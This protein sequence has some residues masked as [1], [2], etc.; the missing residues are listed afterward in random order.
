MRLVSVANVKEPL[1]TR[2]CLER[3]AK[4]SHHTLARLVWHCRVVI[5]GPLSRRN[6]RW[7]DPGIC[8][9]SNSPTAPTPTELANGISIATG[10]SVAATPLG[11]LGIVL[12]IAGLI[13][14]RPVSPPA[15]GGST[16]RKLAPEGLE[17]E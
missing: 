10:P 4:D 3:G 15:L 17:A 14:R 12:V 8:S 5:S 7:H 11:L 6:R 13:R 1:P 2:N 16:E 9:V